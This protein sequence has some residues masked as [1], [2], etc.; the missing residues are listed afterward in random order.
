MDDLKIKL[1]N[2]KDKL[3]KKNQEKSLS[4]KRNH[5]V[6]Q[7]SSIKVKEKTY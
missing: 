5:I 7:R 4:D 2:V 3:S 6:K 1:T